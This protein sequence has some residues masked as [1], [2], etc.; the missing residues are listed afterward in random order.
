MTIE[1]IIQ[2][3]GKYI[4]MFIEMFSTQTFQ[5]TSAWRNAFDLFRRTQTNTILFF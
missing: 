4:T 5:T 3:I 1:D 2:I